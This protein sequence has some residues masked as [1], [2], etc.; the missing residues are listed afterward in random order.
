MTVQAPIDEP[1]AAIPLPRSSV[2]RS[3]NG[4]SIVWSH[5]GPERFEQRVVASEPIDA[6]RIGITAGLEDGTR[7][8]VR[9][10]ELVNQVR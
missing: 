9:G 6:D 2:V 7:I 1:I 4:Q 3:S 5:T 10:A 8:V